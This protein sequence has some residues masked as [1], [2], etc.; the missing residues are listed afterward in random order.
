MDSANTSFT[1]NYTQRFGRSETHTFI[2]C[3]NP[4][5][6]F[7][8]TLHLT[9]IIK[10]TGQSIILMKKYTPCKTTTLYGMMVK[11]KTLDNGTVYN[12]PKR[13]VVF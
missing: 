12:L 7:L 9:V 3:L 10:S 13:C 5:I 11:V 8:Y 4:I 6:R 2:K 1:E